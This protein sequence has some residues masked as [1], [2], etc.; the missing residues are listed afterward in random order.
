[1]QELIPESNI[2]VGLDIGTSRVCVV[3]AEKDEF[4]KLNVLAKECSYADGIRRGTVV[5][6][7]K[8][9]EAIKAAVAKIE[10]E[11]SIEIHGVNVVLSGAYVHCIQS[12]AEISINQTG[13]INQSDVNRFLEM[14]RANIQNLAVN[15][16]IIHVLPQEF[17]VDEGE[18]LLDPIGMAGTIM[19]GRVY[20]VIGLKTKI[21]NIRQCV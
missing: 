11:S 10:R 1:M 9:V 13:I 12:S 6:I 16:E 2:A 14:A 17:I 7:N 5:N 20:I 8:T 4:C 21:R 19:K 15:N 3:V 18:S